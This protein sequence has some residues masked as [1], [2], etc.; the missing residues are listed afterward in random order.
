[1]VD[2]AERVSTRIGI[3]KAQTGILGLDEA[4]GGGLPKGRPALVC[5]GPGCGKTLLAMEFLVRGATQYD[6][7]GVFVAFEENAEELTQNVASLGFDL[8]E[9][10]EQNRISLDYVEVERSQIEEAGEY[11]LEGLFLRIGFAIDAIGAK[12]VVLDTIEALFAGF[13]NE[14]ILR[15]EL[16]RLFRWLKD[17]GVTA[18]ITAERGDGTLTRQGLEEYVSD[19]VILMDHRVHDQVSTR[20]LRI[21]KYRGSAHGT[22]EYPFLIDE[23]GLSV[24]PITSLGLNHTVSGE[25]VSTGIPRLDAMFGGQGLYRGTS[26]L[27]SG[28][29]GSGKSSIAA[30]CAEASCRRQERCLYF[31]FEESP[32]QILRNMRSIGIELDPQRR[33]GLL[34]FHASRPTFYGLEMHL[35][36]MHK[37]IEEFQPRL[38]IVDPVT[39][40]IAAGTETE[41]KAMLMRLID[42]LKSKQI[43]GIFTS[44]TSGGD[45]IEQSEVGVSSL[46]DTWLLLKVVESSGERNRGLYVLKS[47]GMAHSN[48]VRE[49][50]LTDDGIHLM[51]VYVG[52]AGVL[53][54]SARHAQEAKEREEALARQQEIERKR[55]NLERQRRA[56]EAQIAALQ[57][58]FETQEEEIASLVRQEEQRE[59]ALLEDRAEMARLRQADADPTDNGQNRDR[60]RRGEK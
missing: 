5:G 59:A 57:A 42:F 36:M 46:M 60:G 14:A 28:T 7:P 41:A 58:E 44:L 6:E 22:N 32:D 39:N 27:I 31:A 55:R 13:E 35:A 52:P 34:R 19:C 54:G 21:V 1:M 12:R 49:F 43:T 33:D 48:Q 23:D 18:I 20:R 4:T 30:H 9:L 17:K 11:D 50:R 56:V 47:R 53:T 29:A 3:L 24:L 2:T 45:A 40:F 25:R 8:D 38:V 15:A 37:R 10:V 26:V 16:R 51:D